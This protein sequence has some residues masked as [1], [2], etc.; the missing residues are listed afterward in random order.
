MIMPAS[1]KVGDV[2]R[3]E[4]VPDI[5]FEEVTVKAAGRTVEGPVGPVKGA[6]VTRELH[7]DGTTESKTLAPG[8]GEFSTG[9]G[10]DLEALAVAV[11]VNAAAGPEPAAL[12]SMSIGAEGILESARIGDWQAAGATLKRLE[13]TWDAVRT[14]R[15]PRMVAGRLSTSLGVLARA[16]TA[17]RPARVEQAALDVGQ[18]V[19]DLRLRYRPA[20]E[21]DA[22]RFHL[23]SQQLR[24]DAAAGDL[25]GVTGSVAV[26]EWTRDRFAQ[27]LSPAA[28]ADVNARLRQLRAAADA[29]N[30][31]AAADHAARL[32]ARL[33]DLV[34][35]VSA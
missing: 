18:S 19:L 25:A 3:V 11:P 20:A 5:V 7:G 29:G 26:L 2:Y 34:P 32:G 35:T 15:Q 10:R 9:A 13:A 24:V 28:R 27:T 14:A 17:R 31:R 33:R 1:P 21:I 12:A 22:A 23:W 8:Y 6:I 16:V 30:V 4:N